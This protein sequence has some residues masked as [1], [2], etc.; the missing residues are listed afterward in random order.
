M[1]GKIKIGVIIASTRAARNG[2]QIADWVKTT[3]DKD[4]TA[5][6]TYLD[7]AE[8][9]LPFLNEPQTPSGGNYTLESTKAWA[10]QIAPL[11]GFLIVTPEYNHGY[12]ASLKNA[13]DTLY[14]EWDK[15]PVSYVGYGVMGAA[16]SIE[17]LNN[18][19]LQIHMHPIVSAATN[20]LI[21]EHLDQNGQFVPADKHQKAL[22][23][24]LSQLHDWT[25]LLR[26]AR[27]AQ[28]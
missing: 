28:A 18:V 17:Q 2:K 10:A 15:K 19:L 12:P 14:A 21:Y 13:I 25:K 26:A 6:Y 11:D 20:I 5:E 23:Y 7:L 9:N 27:L 4:D 3:T 8:I 22:D 1:E 24:T 16:R